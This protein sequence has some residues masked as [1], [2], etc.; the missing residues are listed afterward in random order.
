MT[1]MISDSD[2]RTL[3]FEAEDKTLRP[4]PE[5]LEAKAKAEARSSIEAETNITV[6]RQSLCFDEHDGCE[7]R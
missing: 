6:F 3:N 5:C 7:V 1:K 2:Y 4:R